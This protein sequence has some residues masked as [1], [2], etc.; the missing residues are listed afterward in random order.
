MPQLSD[1]E[2][3]WDDEGSLAKIVTVNDDATL[4][5]VLA[6]LPEDAEGRPDD[7]SRP[8][9]RNRQG[10]REGDDMA[11]REQPD[12]EEH[13]A[14]QRTGGGSPRELPNGES[15]QAEQEADG[16][17]PSGQPDGGERRGRQGAGGAGMPGMQFSEEPVTWTLTS[18]TV[19]QKQNGEA[20]SVADLAEGTIIRAVLDGTTV[21]SLDIMEFDAGKEPDGS[22]PEMPMTEAET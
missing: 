19:I 14:R 20:A 1:G 16:G 6:Q 12:Q 11:S 8:D 4:T 3:P 21:I 22:Q 7:G 10:G 15:R 5:V 2:N 13:H 9:D 17:R 18:S